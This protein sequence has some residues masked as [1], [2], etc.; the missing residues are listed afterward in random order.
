MRELQFIPDRLADIQKEM[1]ISGF[2]GFLEDAQKKIL[3]IVTSGQCFTDVYY[4]SVGSGEIRQNISALQTQATASSGIRCLFYTEKVVKPAKIFRD[5]FPAVAI[6]Y[7]DECL[8]N[9]P[10]LK[11]TIVRNAGDYSLVLFIN[12]FDS[13]TVCRQFAGLL[14]FPAKSIILPASSVRDQPAESIFS[15]A[16]IQPNTLAALM[17]TSYCRSIRPLFQFLQEI[18]ESENKTIQTRKLLQSQATQ[19]SRKEEQ[20]F[21]QNDL[22]AAIRQ[23]LQKTSQDLDKSFRAKYEELNKPNT[24]K[25]SKNAQQSTSDLHDFR[26][27][28]LAEKSEKVGISIDKDFTDRFLADIRK[29]IT[30]E[31]SKDEPF[32]RMSVDDLISKVNMQLTA[33]G[34][35]PVNKEE[36]YAPFPD[37][38][39]LISSYSY[40]SRT[41]SGELTKKG[42]TEYFIALRDYIGVMMVATGLLAPLNL[43]ASLSDEHS[44]FGFL[45]KL[46][47]GIKIATALLTIGLIIYGVIDLRKRIPRKREEEFEKELGKAREV[48]FQEAKRIFSE[49]SRDWS[50]N[51][52][53]WIKDTIQ[54]LSNLTEKNMK[55]M[56]IARMNKINSD[57]NQQFRMQQSIDLIQR[58]LQSAERIKDAMAT[59]FREIVSETEKE[60]KF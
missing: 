19:I 41:Y 54:N 13:E 53:V 34:I 5:I 11:K 59:R 21:N 35:A 46:S 2:S 25:F 50:A 48:L 4:H 9:D 44:M 3:S 28:D 47:T 43:I 32:L 30:E 40:I 18:F 31:T 60:L 57:K 42:T 45:K 56:L 17:R 33:K 49:S 39:K 52:S 29:A 24:G 7:Y 14:P 51:I 36:V 58:N 20:G 55:D 12:Y 26:K 38:Q 6:I 37:R 22:S 1:G 16:L 8:H 23:L 15:T 10:D 27:M